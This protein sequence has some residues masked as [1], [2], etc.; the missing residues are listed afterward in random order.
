MN[1]RNR[2]RELKKRAEDTLAA[3]P[4]FFDSPSARLRV[5]KI[6]SPTPFPEPKRS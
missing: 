4:I 3:K 5:L 1:R 6:I 2:I